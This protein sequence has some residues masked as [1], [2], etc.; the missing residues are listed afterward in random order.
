[1]GKPRNVPLPEKTPLETLEGKLKSQLKSTKG[2]VVQDDFHD[3]YIAA[4][5]SVL[6][7]IERLK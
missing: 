3:G 1:M 7:E 4:L 5:E 6:R 2:T